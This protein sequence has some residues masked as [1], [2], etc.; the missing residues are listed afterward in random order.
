MCCIVLGHVS[1]RSAFR[2]EFTNQAIKILVRTSL[3]G[4]IHICEVDLT[5][6][7]FFDGLVVPKFESVVEGDGV[8]GKIAKWNL[9][10]MRN[11]VGVEVPYFPYDTEAR[12][13]IDERK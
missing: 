9:D 6:Q 8:N 13:P 12:R 2:K 1:Q 3:L 7:Q 5:L 11:S 10:N 4:A